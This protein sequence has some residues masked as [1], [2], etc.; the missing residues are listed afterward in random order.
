PS[1]PPP[2]TLSPYTTLFRSIRPI[3]CEVG[4]LA[5]THGSA[6]FQ[7]GETQSIVTTTLGT[8]GDEQKID[9]LIGESWKRFMLHYNFPPFSTGEDRKST[10]LNSSHVKISY[11]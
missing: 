5:R 11:A 9:A 10:R 2:P 6:L 4:L 1:P 3:S 8:A 7:R